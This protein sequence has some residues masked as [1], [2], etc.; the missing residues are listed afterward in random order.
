V[1][2]KFIFG[3]QPTVALKFSSI[4][5]FL[6]LTFHQFAFDHFTMLTRSPEQDQKKEATDQD[7]RDERTSDDGRRRT[8][9]VGRVAGVLYQ[10]K[11]VRTGEFCRPS[12]ARR[13]AKWVWRCAE[14]ERVGRVDSV[15]GVEISPA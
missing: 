7:Q 15:K 5:P 13:F 14:L 1:I 4:S 9:V 3:N 2:A 11:L 10:D 8:G 6:P 12:E